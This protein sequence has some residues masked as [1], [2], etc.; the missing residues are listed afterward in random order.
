MVAVPTTVLADKSSDTGQ[1]KPPIILQ[2]ASKGV[3]IKRPKAPSRQLVTCSYDGSTLELNFKI[4]EG[5][6]TITV[7]DETLQCVTYTIDTSELYVSIPVGP[8]YG[9]ISVTLDTE[10]GNHFEG[11]I[12]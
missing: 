9:S 8:L 6:S 1:G 7:T 4:S 2:Q 11:T 10:L 5:M 12:E 3:I